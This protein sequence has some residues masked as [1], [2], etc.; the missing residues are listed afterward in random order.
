M[1]PQTDRSSPWR[2]RP[3]VGSAGEA[4]ESSSIDVEDQTKG[5]QQP[6]E[7]WRVET[8]VEVIESLKEATEKR[9]K[10]FHGGAAQGKI[11][12]SSV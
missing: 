12:R 5:E 11:R 8:W 9:N 3:D 10:S 1:L 2:P 7:S 6:G 4:L